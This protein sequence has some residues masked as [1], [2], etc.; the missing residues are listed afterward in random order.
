MKNFITDGVRKART[1]ANG[2]REVEVITDALR[3]I[4]RAVR[5]REAV[6]DVVEEVVNVGNAA[7]YCDLR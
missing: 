3:V 1:V 5:L 7:F 2:V 6:C 4:C